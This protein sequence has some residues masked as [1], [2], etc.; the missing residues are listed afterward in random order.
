MGTDSAILGGPEALEKAENLIGPLRK[1]QIFKCCLF[2]TRSCTDGPA[3][4]KLVGVLQYRAPVAQ[5]IERLFPK[6]KV[7]GSNP[8]WRNQLFP[9]PAQILYLLPVFNL[10]KSVAII[11]SMGH[12]VLMWPLDLHAFTIVTPSIIANSLHQVFSSIPHIL[13]SL[14][15]P[16]FEKNINETILTKY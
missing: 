10:K 2:V 12:V 14:V 5:W 15:K 11:S 9:F 8:S 13:I 4:E 1:G 7:E 6:Q 3:Q 16:F